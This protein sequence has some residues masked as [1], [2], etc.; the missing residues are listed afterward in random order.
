M[1]T[2][3]IMTTTIMTFIQNYFKYDETHCKKVKNNILNSTIKH[4]A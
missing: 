1:L 3:S 2:I 4:L